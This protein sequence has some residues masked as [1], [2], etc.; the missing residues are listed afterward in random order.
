MSSLAPTQDPVLLMV[1][2]RPG[3][4]AP[5]VHPLGQGETTIG[6]RPEN[7][8]VLSDMRVARRHCK[9]IL[10]H[11]GLRVVDLGSHCGVWVN[12]QRAPLANE[13]GHPLV[14]GDRLLVGGVELAVDK[15]SPSSH[16][17]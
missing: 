1:E 11:E 2:V 16:R 17:A 10:D 13:G 7:D 3:S 12:G 15:A 5:L 8:I 14:P 9:L 6:R 4:S